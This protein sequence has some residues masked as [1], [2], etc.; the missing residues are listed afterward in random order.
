MSKSL[1]LALSLV[2]S[3]S[4]A[5]VHAQGFVQSIL[6]GGPA[7]GSAQNPSLVNAGSTNLPAGQYMLT[8][9]NSGQALYVVVN[10]QG[11]L[12][13]QDPRYLEINVTAPANAAAIPGTA[14]PGAAIPGQQQQS[15]G[16]FSG[17]LKQGFESYMQKKMT[18]T[19]VQ[20]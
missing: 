15:G 9:L 4:L 11:Q 20:P 7:Q 17:L 1:F 14:I 19:Q 3:F 12:L 16:G 18:P 13:A 10:A 6:G 2:F 8:N 5:P